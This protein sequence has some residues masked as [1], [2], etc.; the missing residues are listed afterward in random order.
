MRVLCFRIDAHK[1]MY[2]RF[3]VFRQAPNTVNVFWKK[4]HRT[5]PLLSTCCC[6]IFLGLGR[7]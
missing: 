6:Q 4:G 7:V 1:T 3:Y 5:R 2:A